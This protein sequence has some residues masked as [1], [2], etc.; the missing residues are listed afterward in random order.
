VASR[1]EIFAGIAPSYSGWRHFGLVNAMALALIVSALALVRAPTVAEL[2]LV[3]AAFLFA[4]WGEW[5]LH[6]DVLHRRVRGFGVLYERHALTHHVAFHHDT[7]AAP[8]P[9]EWRWVLFPAPALVGLVALVAPVALVLARLWS[10][11]AGLLF[12]ATGVGFY[13]LYEWCHL[14]YH[15]PEASFVGRLALVRVLRRHHQRHHH[16][17]LAKRYN[18]NVTFPIWDRVR[19]T[20]APAE[21][22]ARADEEIARGE[23]A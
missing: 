9:R 17:A 13:L 14:S 1:D 11:N 19:G 21:A 22:I 3:P 18:F 8:S 23:R 10:R 4:N 15:Q 20:V 2:A 5:Q 7:M 16:P 12:L 6:R